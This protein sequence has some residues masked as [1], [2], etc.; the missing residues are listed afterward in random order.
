MKRELRCEDARVELSARLDG[1]VDAVTSRSLDEHMANCGACRRHEASLRRMRTALRVQPAEAVPDLTR[2]IMHEVSSH[3][4]RARRRAEWMGGLRIGSVAAAVA[5]LLLFG[6]SLPFGNDQPPQSAQAS[7]IAERVRAAAQELEA[8]RATFSVVERGW[9]QHVDIRRFVARVWFD[10]PENFRLQVRDLT[11]Y[12]DERWPENNVDLI[13]NARRWWVDEPST[14]PSEALPGCATS[15]GSEQRTVVSRQPFDGTST[16]PTDIIVPLETLASTRDFNILGRERVAGRSMIKVALPYRQAVPLVTALQP[17]GLWRSFHPLDR[18][19][20]WLDTQTWFPLRY[21]VYADTSRERAMWAG[22]QGLHDRADQQLLSVRATSFSKPS[23][24][25][26]VFHAPVKGITRS[27]GFAERD[28]GETASWIAPS[29]LAGLKPYRA[30]V[31]GSQQTL[32]YASGMTWLKVTSDK[33][34]TIGNETAQEVKLT[35]DS[36]AYYQP[37]TEE[38]KRRID[39]FGR[40][41]QVHLESN[42]ARSTLLRIASSVGVDGKRIPRT[43][44]HDKQ[45]TVLR[46]DPEGALARSA[47]AAAPHYLPAGYEPSAALLSKSRTGERTLTVYYRR[48]EAEYSGDGIRITQSPSIKLLSPSAEQSFG[49]STSDIHKARWFP[50]RG[51]LEWIDG[52]VYRSVTVPSLD[53][54]TAVR[55]GASLR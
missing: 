15:A 18:V 43:L 46:L 1:E 17:G 55:I 37:A 27:G 4:M 6:T 9:N 19:E 45:R 32:T 49:V 36:I 40:H 29:Y 20:I 26:S 10:A 8:Y 54:E 48:Q 11:A 16:L 12:P 21:D 42:L 7:E 23:I 2:R 3:G 31:S 22:L 51:E 47:F 39:I 30:G 41:S 34:R 14:C 44:E 28:F 13:A 25:P 38:L 35:D 33:S 24:P 50:E 53:L 5:A 52:D